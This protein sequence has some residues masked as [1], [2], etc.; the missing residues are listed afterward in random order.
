LF[1][2]NG[3]DIDLYEPNKIGGRLSVINVGGRDYE[4]GG[5]IIHP[6]NKYMVDFLKLLGN[7]GLQSYMFSSIFY[8]GCTHLICTVLKLQSNK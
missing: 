3:V 1:G 7:L 6:K 5:S 4:V 8:F 2:P